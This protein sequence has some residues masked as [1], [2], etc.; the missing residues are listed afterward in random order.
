MNRLRS[1]AVLLCAASFASCDY[2]KIAVQDITGP[3]P[4]A[5][6]KFFNFGLNAPAVNFYANDTKMTAIFTALG[7]ESTVGVGYGEVGAGGLYS[8]IEP[9]QY[10]LSGRISAATDKDLAISSLSASMES[11][12][13]YSFYQSGPYNSST[14]TVD[15]FIVEDNFPAEI[16]WSVATVRFVH[17]IYN[18]NPMTLYAVDRETGEEVAIGGEVAYKSAGAFVPVPNAV[19]DLRTRYAGSSTSVITRNSVG[20]LAGRVYTITVRGDINVAPTSTTA[21]TG[22]VRTCLDNTLNR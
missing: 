6:V 22:T 1:V 14:K 5:K 12:K 18:A 13:A 4:A 8:G 17:A 9:G 21:C 20:F 2:E 3:L 7:A 11:G 15:A 16:D 19:Y 10:T